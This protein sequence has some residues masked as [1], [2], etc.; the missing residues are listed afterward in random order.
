MPADSNRFLTGAV[1]IGG[2]VAC[3]AHGRILRRSTPRYFRIASTMFSTMLINS[4]APRMIV[5]A[6]M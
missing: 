3:V 1:R 5:M 2:S 6:G 4:A